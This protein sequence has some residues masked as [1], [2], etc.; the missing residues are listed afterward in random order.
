MGEVAAWRQLPAWCQ[1]NRLLGICAGFW[2]LSDFPTWHQR[3]GVLPGNQ[4]SASSH[5]G[6]GG[7]TKELSGG[8]GGALSF[9]QC[10][11]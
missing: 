7:S 4:S 11:C 5:H 3:L 2:L 1:G 8:G 10:K 9:L 6:D